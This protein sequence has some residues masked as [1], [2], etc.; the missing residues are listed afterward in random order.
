M[1]KGRLYIDGEDIYTK[2]GVYVVKGGWNELIAYPPLKSVTYNDW[3][4]QDGVEAD[5]SNPVLNTHDVQI[6]FAYDGDKGAFL[7]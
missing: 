1:L 6:K 5:L 7:L 3:Q 2:Y 4:E